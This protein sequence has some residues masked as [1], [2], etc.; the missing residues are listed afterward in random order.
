MR[1]QQSGKRNGGE[2][3]GCTTKWVEAKLEKK[4]EGIKIF[5]YKKTK[6]FQLL[7]DTAVQRYTLLPSQHKE[8]SSNVVT[9]L[10]DKQRN[11][12]QIIEYRT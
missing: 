6:H 5:S 8:W 4:T 1:Y 11:R 2:S 9:Q 3:S 12:L 10:L 7:H